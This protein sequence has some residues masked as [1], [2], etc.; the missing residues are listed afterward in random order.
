[1]SQPPSGQ[2]CFKARFDIDKNLDES[3]PQKCGEEVEIK[4]APGKASTFSELLDAI[5]PTGYEYKITVGG[6]ILSKETSTPLSKLK[7]FNAMLEKSGV[8]EAEG[9]KAGTFETLLAQSS[10]ECRTAIR[11]AL[12]MV[13]PGHVAQFIRQVEGLTWTCLVTSATKELLQ[14]KIIKGSALELST[15]KYECPHPAIYIFPH[16]TSTACLHA[17]GVSTFESGKETKISTNEVTG[18]IKPTCMATCRTSNATFY[19]IGH[20]D[21][22]C[23]LIKNLKL[24]WQKKGSSDKP[25]QSIAVCPEMRKI[26]CVHDDT[27]RILNTLGEEKGTQS[28]SNGRVCIFNPSNGDNL[29][30]G[31]AD[32]KAFRWKFDESKLSTINSGKE[33]ECI[34]CMDISPDG[35]LLT[36]AGETNCNFV[37]L[38]NN[39]SLFSLLCIKPLNSVQFNPMRYWVAMGGE[40]GVRIF[41]LEKKEIIQDISSNV[42]CTGMGWS[43]FGMD[44]WLCFA[45]GSVRRFVVKNE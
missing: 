33:L 4:L 17:G 34:R 3:F 31:S 16:S 19:F 18:K 1:M 30:I 44:L 9:K 41:D 8:A 21:G 43:A 28:L 12:P 37:D 10:Q 23:S 39:A 7:L 20:N 32:G 2:R 24:V 22:S 14:L 15:E 42:A 38:S 40:R 35:A 26:A 5:L 11:N 36:M 45:N 29:I 25:V 13:K 6:L 27:A